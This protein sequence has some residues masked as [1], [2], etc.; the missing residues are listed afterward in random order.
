MVEGHPVGRIGGFGF[1]PDPPAEGEE[2]KLVL[3]AARRALREEMPRRVARAGGRAGRR[4][5]ADRRII[6]I[7]W[8]GVPVARLRRGASALRPRVQVL[9]SEFLDGAQRERVR[10]RL[11]RFVDDRIRADL[12]PLFAA[13]DLAREPARRCA[14][15]C[16]G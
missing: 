3:R 4:L 8:D 6:G 12:A 10:A 16:I 13:A 2:K 11:Q 9:D 14:A 15:R 5:R 7:T 1:F